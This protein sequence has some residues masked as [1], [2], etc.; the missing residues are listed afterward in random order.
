MGAH[1]YAAA[2]P[3]RC[4]C[5]AGQRLA[6]AVTS[7]PPDGR[8]EWD[9]GIYHRVSAPHVAWGGKVL[10]RLSLAGD[11]TVVDAG[12]GTGRLTADL[13]ERLPHGRVVAVDKSTNMLAEAAA[14]LVPRFGDRVS[15]LHADVQDLELPQPVDV[16][17]STAMF[18]W[19][20]DH[21]RLFRSLFACLKPGGRLVAQCGGGPN[22]ARLRQR[23]NTLL[24]SPD[25]RAKATGLMNPWE[26]ATPEET[27][28]RL[29]AAGFTE[30][31]TSLEPAPTTFPDP[32]AFRE[33]VQSVVLRAHLDAILEVADRRAFMAEITALAAGDNPALTL[34]YWRLNLA[35]T[36]PLP[37]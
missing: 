3:E 37:Q 26:F 11:E 20:L 36:R 22:I 12:C 33:F 34:D 6:V 24:E 2:G 15:F 28:R 18:H 25:F 1:C 8:D 14:H 19:V 32:S 35:A 16:I 27:S 10:A 13:L 21:P 5:A 30:I 9:A 23:A 4:H 31:E 17:F 29:A 7:A